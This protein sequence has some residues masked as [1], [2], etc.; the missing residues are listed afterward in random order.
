MLILLNINPISKSLFREYKETI[1]ITK[2]PLWQNT[3]LPMELKI[4]MD[5]SNNTHFRKI[6]AAKLISLWK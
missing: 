2:N 3:N 6:A 4:E 5:L 1:Q